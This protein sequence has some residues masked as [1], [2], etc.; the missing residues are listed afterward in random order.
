M[1]DYFLPMPKLREYQIKDV[2][3]LSKL[4]C[5]ACLNEQRTGKTPTALGIIHTQKCKRVLIVCPGSA[6]YRWKEEFEL[7]LKRPCIVLDGTPQQRQKKLKNWTDGLCITYDTLKLINHTDAETQKNY[8]TGELKNILKYNIDAVIVDEFHRARNKN[9]L[10]AKAL[11]K[12]AKQIPNRIAL[13]G[14]PAYSKQTDIWTLLH[15]LYPDIFTNYWDF[16]DEYFEVDLK[17]SPNGTYREI[18]KLKPEKEKKLQYFLNQISTQ[19]KQK[20]PEVMPWLQKTIVSPIYLDPTSTQEKHLKM[21]KDYY[22]TESVVC[23]GVIDRLIRYR[24]ICQDPKLLTLSG[25]SAKTNWIKEYFKDYPETPT[26]FFSNFT[27]Y[28][29]QLDTECTISHRI[30]CGDTPMKTRKEIE[31]DFQAGHFNY[32]FMNIKAGK[33][34]LTLDR[35]ERIVFLDVCPPIGDIQQAAER[36]T[37]TSESKNQIP[38]EI[39]YLILKNTFDEDL[40]NAVIEGATMTDVLN[41]FKEYINLED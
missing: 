18:G 2:K 25:T 8:K 15:F 30:L 32:L 26:I 28:L 9:T 36:F 19:R 34:S 21:L 23:I 29:K 24:Q 27:Q 38:K 33:E 5:S 14:T 20:D 4:K 11:F 10:L 16:V 22:E 1:G 40:Y 6:L 39:I 12:L 17:W 13:T 37:A 31:N 35:A 41:N 7:W 3:K